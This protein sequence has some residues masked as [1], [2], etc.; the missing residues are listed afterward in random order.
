M[1]HVRPMA[2]LRVGVCLMGKRAHLL[3][4]AWARVFLRIIPKNKRIF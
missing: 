3:A 2:A 1:K 4:P